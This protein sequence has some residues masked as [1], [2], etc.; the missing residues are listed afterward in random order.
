ML[1]LG[2][3]VPQDLQLAV[4]TTRDATGPLRLPAT[5]YE[6]DPDEVAAAHIVLLDRRLAG[7]PAAAAP[8]VAFRE[9][10]AGIVNGEWRR[11]RR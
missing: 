1:E 5:V 7:E 3:R 11:V 10:A 8:V 6:I 4:Q 9:Q 2:V